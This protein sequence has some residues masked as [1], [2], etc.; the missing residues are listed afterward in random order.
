MNM[1]FPLHNLLI[2]T[3]LS[4]KEKEKV[5]KPSF[6]SF[7]PFPPLYSYTHTYYIS[8]SINRITIEK[9]KKKKPRFLCK[10]C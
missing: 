6:L 10:P 1:V 9:K 8:G 5:L 2:I 3:I 7:T 4:F